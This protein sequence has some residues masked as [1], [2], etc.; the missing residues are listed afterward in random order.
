MEKT[1][2]SGVAI[3]LSS[4]RAALWARLWDVAGVVGR[5]SLGTFL[6]SLRFN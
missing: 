2:V 5:P 6:L 1:I 3:G 4:S